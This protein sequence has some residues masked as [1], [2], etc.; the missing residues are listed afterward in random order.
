[1]KEEV[2]NY[3]DVPHGFGLCAAGECPNSSTCLRQI[4]YRHLPENIIFLH[5]LRPNVAKEMAEEC[6]YY[7]SNDKVRYAKGFKR[8]TEALSVRVANSFRHRL[9]ASWGVRRYYQRRKGETLL[10]PAEQQQVIMLAKALGVH[11]TEYF[12]GYIE[13]YNWG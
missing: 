10:P 12:D 1:M 6:R 5:L 3:S 8:T 11:Q 4:A 13:E 2:I 9:V 7:R